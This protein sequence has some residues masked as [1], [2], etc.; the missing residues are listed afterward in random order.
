MKF[1]LLMLPIYQILLVFFLITLARCNDRSILPDIVHQYKIDLHSLQNPTRLFKT[2]EE[3]IIFSRVKFLYDSY[4]AGAKHMLKKF[5]YKFIQFSK[6]E[7]I[8]YVIDKDLKYFNERTIN[9]QNYLMT[10]KLHNLDLPCNNL[11]Y[12]CS[13]GELKREYK[14]KLK[15]V[16][17]STNKKIL[18]ELT[19]VKANKNCIVLTIG[20]FH[21]VKNV[22]Y[23]CFDEYEDTVFYSNLLSERILAN[24]HKDYSGTIRLVDQVNF[25][26]L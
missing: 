11:Q 20:F 10:L 13:L 22:A 18:E 16:D 4:E 17:F 9:T 25:I 23:L 24:Y 6:E 19:D 3:G 5:D 15:D 26:F 8:I 7:I 21:K 12:I 14:N 1:T 2:K